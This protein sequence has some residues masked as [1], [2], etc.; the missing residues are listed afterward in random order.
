MG[1]GHIANVICNVNI[2]YQIWRLLQFTVVF[3]LLFF[4]QLVLLLLFIFHHLHLFLLF[5]QLSL[6][7][8]L[9]LL[10]ILLQLLLL[11]LLPFYF[12]SSPA[13]PYI[14]FSSY[15]SFYFFF[16]APSLISSFSLHFP[17]SLI[18]VIFLFCCICFF[19]FFFCFL[20]IGVNVIHFV[21]VWGF[22]DSSLMPAS[23]LS[24]MVGIRLN[25]VGAFEM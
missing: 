2:C 24:R 16:L 23:P 18:S 22:L 25:K 17:P 6:L 20:S 9:L 12:F 4:I 5:L 14:F 21:E 7:P 11:V 19:C 1:N 10:L 3:Y 8:L 13:S 15:F